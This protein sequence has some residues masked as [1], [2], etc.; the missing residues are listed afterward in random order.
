MQSSL[1]STTLTTLTNAHN[2]CHLFPLCA[3]YN[4]QFIHI[5][6]ILSLRLW[7]HIHLNAFAFDITLI[8]FNFAL[9]CVSITFISNLMRLQLRTVS[10]AK[11]WAESVLSLSCHEEYGIWDFEY[12]ISRVAL[13]LRVSGYISGT[14]GESDCQKQ[15]HILQCYLLIDETVQNLWFCFGKTYFQTYKTELILV[16]WVIHEI[17]LFAHKTARKLWI[18]E[19]SET[20]FVIFVY[21][22]C[23]IRALKW[24]CTQTVRFIFLILICLRLSLV[25]I[26]NL[27]G[28][29]EGEVRERVTEKS[30]LSPQF[31]SLLS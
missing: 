9:R 3:S 30:F 2:S 16:E 17:S 18:L 4:I 20:V 23:I 7:S 22:V 24:L 6:H 28:V 29:A 25:S 21:Y 26:N 8:I 19:N 5:S 27:I 31:I 14:H 13:D 15:T 11:I 10:N 1:D 12:C